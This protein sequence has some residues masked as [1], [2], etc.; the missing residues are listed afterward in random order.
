MAVSGPARI[1]R[2]FST[3]V[4]TNVPGVELNESSA[5]RLYRPNL[6][7]FLRVAVPDL[8]ANGRAAVL[9]TVATTERVPHIH[10]RPD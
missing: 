1:T 2:L 8:H 3:L 10:S 5:S 4:S 6:V 9:R 7:G